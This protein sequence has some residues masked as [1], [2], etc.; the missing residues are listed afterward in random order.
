MFI[1][2]YRLKSWHILLSIFGLALLA[3]L[4]G[5][6]VGQANAQHASA[7]LPIG[8]K[9]PVTSPNAPNVCATSNYLVY[10]STSASLVPGTTL[11]SGSQGDDVVAT[12]PLPFNYT[13]YNSSYSSVSASSNGTLQFVS[14]S[15]AYSN[16]CL[17]TATFNY[18]ILPFWDDLY[19]GDTAGGQGIYTSISGVSPNRIFNIEWR[20]NLCCSTGILY[21]F[22][23]R[24]YEGQ[25]YF[26]IIYAAVPNTGSGATIGV[27]KDTG[28]LYT[29][30]SCNTSSVSAGLRLGFVQPNCTTCS[31]G[32]YSIT[33]SQGAAIAPGTALATS[34]QGDDV[35]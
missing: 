3:G 7:A 34:S 20:A 32:D 5:L 8:V 24:L 17:P 33:T 25:N 19:T 12:I 26:E 13:L 18:A 28:S 29:Q 6:F 35:V 15:N 9:P 11:V 30:W 14:T 23:V 10:T 27:Q 16:V 21:N 4:L 1:R 2:A 22:E 31:N